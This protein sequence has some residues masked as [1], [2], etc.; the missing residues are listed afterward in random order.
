MECS[1]SITDS[2]NDRIFVRNIPSKTLQPYLSSRPAMTKYSILPI[3]EPYKKPRVNLETFASY[4][5]SH[6]FN[7]GNN[8]APWS[9]FAESINT[10]SELRNQIYALQRGSQA[11]YVPSSSSDLYSYARPI[12]KENQVKQPFPLLFSSEKLSASCHP[13]QG[14]KLFNNST[15]QMLLEEHQ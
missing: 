12:S 5:V 6:T 14:N 13:V 3:V 11:V 1:S 4:N 7:P 8:V 15:R 2:I 10:E 9:G